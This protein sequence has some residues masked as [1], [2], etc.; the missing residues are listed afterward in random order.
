MFAAWKLCVSKIRKNKVH[1][2][3]TA[4]IILMSTLLLATALVILNNT[5]NS[6]LDINVVNLVSKKP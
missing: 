1:N 5:S 6:Y 3:L 4:L 2:A